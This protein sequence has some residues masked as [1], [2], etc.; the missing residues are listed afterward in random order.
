MGGKAMAQGMAASGL[1]GSGCA[2]SPFHGILQR[3][4]VEVMA[5]FF[6]GSWIEQS[7]CAGKTY[8][9]PHSRPALVYFRSSAKG[10]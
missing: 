4:L 6:A 2:Y 7:L 1:D 10:K 8:C 3:F 9:H 5:T